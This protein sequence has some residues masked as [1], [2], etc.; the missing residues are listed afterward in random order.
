MIMDLSAIIPTIA[1]ALAV[2][3]LIR[4][5]KKYL[6]NYNP[7]G[8]SSTIGTIKPHRGVAYLT[9]TIFVIFFILGCLAVVF[10]NE[11]RFIA[12]LVALFGAFGVFSQISSF[13]TVHDVDWNNDDFSGPAQVKFQ[14]MSFARNKLNWSEIIGIGLVKGPYHYLEDKSGNR[15]YW[16]R[17]YANYENFEATVNEKCPELN[18][19]KFEIFPK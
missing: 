8:Y 5:F 15:I 19:P 9:M 4:W 7:V 13:T 16:S 11:S 1:S 14:M 3:L 17:S 6:D 10:I 2:T 12:V 18:W